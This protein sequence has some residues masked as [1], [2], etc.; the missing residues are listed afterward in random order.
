MRETRRSIAGV[1]Q[2]CKFRW[3]VFDERNAQIRMHACT[4]HRRRM[5]TLE[6]A[7]NSR[8]SRIMSSACLTSYCVVR[9]FNVTLDAS[10]AHAACHS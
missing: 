5:G 1:T 9:L 8:S 3:D 4:R 10:N 6:L 2:G 7:R